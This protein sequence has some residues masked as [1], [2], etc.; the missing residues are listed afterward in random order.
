MLS[1]DTIV[2]ERNDLRLRLKA[3]LRLVE[4]T[5]EIVDAQASSY[6]VIGVGLQR[7]QENLRQARNRVRTKIIS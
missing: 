1:R 7:V 6:D 3:L 5:D 2:H 4:Q